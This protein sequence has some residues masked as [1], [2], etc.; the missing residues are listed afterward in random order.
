[1]SETQK[2]EVTTNGDAIKNENEKAAKK[3]R[4]ASWWDRQPHDVKV[5]FSVAASFTGFVVACVAAST[6][7]ETIA[8]AN[9]RSTMNSR[10]FKEMLDR[11]VLDPVPPPKT[12]EEAAARIINESPR[13]L[14][15]PDYQAHS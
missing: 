11:G 1:M 7:A 10:G 5:I 2:N 9:S 6:V 8:A 4:I 15:M 14:P 13:I 12:L 3:G